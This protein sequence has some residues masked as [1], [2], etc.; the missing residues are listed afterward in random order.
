MPG[1]SD[2][3]VEP[4]DAVNANQYI[5]VNA[6]H[7]SGNDETFLRHSSVLRKFLD[8]ALTIFKFRF[9]IPFGRFL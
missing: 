2:I 7:Y 6:N 3:L 8:Y 9:L 5:Y 1:F 4:K